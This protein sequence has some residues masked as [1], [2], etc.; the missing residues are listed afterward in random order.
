MKKIIFIIAA[1]GFFIGAAVYADLYNSTTTKKS[2]FVS[3]YAPAYMNYYD[4]NSKYITAKFN[5]LTD[6]AERSLSGVQK[7]TYKKVKKIERAIADG[8]F[9]KA[10]KEDIDFL[11]THI[12]YYNYLASRQNL[13]AALNEMI[14]IKR[15]NSTDRVLDD[16]IVSYKLGMLFYLNKNYQGALT[17][18]ANFANKHNPSEDNLLY[19]LGDIYFRLNKYAYSISNLSKIQPTSMNYIPAQEILYQDYYNIGEVSKAEDCAKLLVKY[20]PNAQNYLRLVE[21]SGANDLEKTEMLNRAKDYALTNSDE[22]SLLLA[23]AHK[24]KI[25]Q[26]KID[27]AVSKLTGFAEKPDWSKIYNE[28]ASIIKPLELSQRQEHFF[29][30][31]NT[32]ISRYNG[33]DL[34]KCFEYVNREEE[35]LTAKLMEDYRQAYQEKLMELEEIRRQQQFLQQTYFERLYWDDFFYMKHPYFFGYW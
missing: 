15:L 29:N 25:E 24:A 14:S 21:V 20:K 30:S 4:I 16:E 32:C 35:K 13:Q 31:T 33:E 26:K 6:S 18:L 34:K 2:N 27:V 23:D 28:I 22:T 3:I 11:P 1:I 12:Q 7:E 17:Y 5:P 8:N 9:Q 10:I 19:A